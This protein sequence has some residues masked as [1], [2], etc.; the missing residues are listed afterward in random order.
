MPTTTPITP[1]TNFKVK[2]TA[3]SSIY[4]NN[5]PQFNG[6]NI[7]DSSNNFFSIFDGCTAMIENVLPASATSSLVNAQEPAVPVMKLKVTARNCSLEIKRLNYLQVN[8]PYYQTFAPFSGEVIQND[9]RT[10][11]GLLYD[12]RITE[13]VGFDS[14]DLSNLDHPYRIAHWYN[15]FSGE[16]NTSQFFGWLINGT[17]S[18]VGSMYGLNWVADLPPALWNSSPNGSE[19]NPQQFYDK[20]WVI[21]KDD[22]VINAG[23]FR[24]F[25]INAKPTRTVLKWFHDNP[26][27]VSVFGLSNDDNSDDYSYCGVYA[28]QNPPNGRREN[29]NIQLIL[30]EFDLE[31][32]QNPD[33]EVVIYTPGLSAPTSELINIY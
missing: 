22:V 33:D 29:Q 6:V 18:Y 10:R 11:T 25:N 32:I 19:S 15:N 17:A 13:Q 27:S 24:I 3:S 5:N 9:P 8:L 1:G 2:I 26:C 21:F 14:V 16:S 30:S 12:F 28:D 7:N 31:N 23:S 4:P 20:G